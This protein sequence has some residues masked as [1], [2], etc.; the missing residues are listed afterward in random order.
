MLDSKE[1]I[2]TFGAHVMKKHNMMSRNL[3]K[4]ILQTM[5]LKHFHFLPALNSIKVT[6]PSMRFEETCSLRFNK[7]NCWP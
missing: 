3:T 5:R 2:R 6:T 4:I 7:S 1:D